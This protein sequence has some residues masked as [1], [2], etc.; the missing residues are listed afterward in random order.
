MR[1]NLTN[2]RCDR[3]FSNMTSGVS[4]VHNGRNPLTGAKLQDIR[5]LN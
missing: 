1:V 4:E 2:Y 5:T 3:N